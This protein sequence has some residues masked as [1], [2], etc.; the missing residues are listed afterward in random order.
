MN[1]TP[2]Q[3]KDPAWWDANAPEGAEW[4][5]S[6]DEEFH[7]DK[8]TCS[9][10]VPRPTTPTWTGSGLPPVGVVCEYT[11]PDNNGTV[12]RQWYW[13]KVVAYDEGAPVVRTRAGRYHRKS[14]DGY[15]FRP[16]KTHKQRVVEK[17]INACPYPDSGSTM[18]DVE[19]LYDAGMLVD[20]D[21]SQ[22]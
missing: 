17:A 8:N 20:P 1:P 10:C 22:N 13:C 15:I 4:F 21:D 18:R 14:L 11:M 5:C 12:C 6:T 9:D 19:A 3:L 16:L 7:S 2:E